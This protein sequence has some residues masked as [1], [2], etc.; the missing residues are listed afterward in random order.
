[1]TP[2]TACKL[3]RG[4]GASDYFASSTFL[5][6]LLGCKS[7]LPRSSSNKNA[8]EF[9]DPRIDR[10]IRAALAVHRASRE[11]RVPLC[12]RIDRGRRGGAVGSGLQPP[13]PRRRI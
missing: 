1:V 12:A 10:Q 9:S 13:S 6:A 8:S 5:G 7:F 2:E 4:A 11:E 3:G